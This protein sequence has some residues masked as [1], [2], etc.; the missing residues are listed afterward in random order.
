MPLK[1]GPR[2]LEKLRHV[3]GPSYEAIEISRARPEAQPRLFL[4]WA[5]QTGNPTQPR[6]RAGQCRVSPI[7][8][9]LFSTALL[10]ERFGFG[11]IWFGRLVSYGG[12]FL[13]G[14]AVAASIFPMDALNG[15]ISLT[16]PVSGDTAQHIVGQRYFLADHWHWPPFVT[17]LIDAPY[18]VNIALTDSTPLVAML[19]RPWHDWLPYGAH[20]IYLWVAIC[21]VMQPIAAVFALRSAGERRVV[22]ALAAAMIAIS[23]PAFIFRFN[24]A[25]LCGHFLILLTIGLYFKILRRPS[26]V[27]WLGCPVLL[28]IS[29]L[30]HPYF[31]AMV[32]GML[33]AAPISLAIRREYRVALRLTGKLL[34]SF[35][36]L[37]ACMAAGGYLGA[38][39]ATG[40]G[41][42]SL[43]LL[44]PFVPTGSAFIGGYAMTDATGGQFEGYSY[45]GLGGLALGLM[46]LLQFRRPSARTRLRNHGGLFVVAIGAL[47]FAVSDQ[48]YLGHHHLFHLP[49]V[50]ATLQQFR[51]S[52][53]FVWVD[54]YLLVVCATLLI[55]RS[56]TPVWA[57]TALLLMGVVQYADAGLLRSQV[58][59]QLVQQTP[60]AVD[61]AF[62][63]PMLMRHRQLT[64][65]PTA[66]CQPDMVTNPLFMNLLLLASEQALPVNTIPVARATGADDCGAAAVARP[67]LNPG[68]LRLLLPGISPNLVAVL[69]DWRTQCHRFPAGMIGC[70][71]DPSLS[72]LPKIEI[73]SI[74]L[75]RDL[76]LGQTEGAQIEGQGWTPAS[77]AGAWTIGA[78]ASLLG[79][80]PDITGAMRLTMTAHGLARSGNSQQVQVRANGQPIA[81]WDVVQDRDVAYSAVIPAGLASHGSL[82]IDLKITDPVRPSDVMGNGD[83]RLLGFFLSKFRLDQE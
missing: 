58:K 18:G 64:L 59:Q 63:R 54:L 29:L 11:S 40:F 46:A 15:T 44:S 10:R 53:R 73:A 39:L 16:H 70:S 12:A 55:S 69:P 36:L 75:G 1:A 25:A 6:A 82:V 65:W 35:A 45:L 48:V 24:H 22:P 83:T 78:D 2:I 61:P 68:E 4:T 8:V 77:A 52:G 67:T 30:V 71:A 50:P 14:L 17:Q 31:V 56:M 33:L 7:L 19:A 13:L 34:A 27:W 80:I 28:V 79:S 20:F 62:I 51:A 23:M 41:Y 3:R 81:T 43:N 32:S 5:M 66:A 74:P 26:T 60:W 47:L 57:Y 37:G 38:D 9:S 72:G 21:F 42:Y 76:S 49:I